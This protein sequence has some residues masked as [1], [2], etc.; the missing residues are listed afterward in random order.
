M[1]EEGIDIS[2]FQGTIDWAKVKSDPQNIRFVN[3]KATEGLTYVDGMFARNRAGAEAVGLKFGAYHYFHPNLDPV[4]QA[5]FFLS[6]VGNDLYRQKLII[7]IEESDGL[8]TS[9]VDNALQLFL[10]TIEKRTGILCEIYTG[11]S[12]AQTNMTLSKFSKYPLWIADY[13]VTYPSV[14]GWTDWQTKDTGHVDGIQGNVDMDVER[15]PNYTATSCVVDNK[16]YRALIVNN[17]TYPIWTAFQD[18]GVT[19]T[20][21]AYGD[22]EVNHLKADQVTDG[23]DTYLNWSLLKLTQPPQMLNGIQ[24]FTTKTN[25]ID[26]VIGLLN[27]AITLLKGGQ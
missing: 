12:F 18:A 17:T 20:K 11:A 14:V 26:D 8:S 5:N 3:A 24:H 4:A 19:I 16:T 22:I 6:V 25:H 13:G 10:D 15:M 23:T 7:D 9:E 21:I 2:K 27:Q 1:T